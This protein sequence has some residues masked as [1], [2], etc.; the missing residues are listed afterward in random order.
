MPLTRLF[1]PDGQPVGEYEFE[2][3]SDQ[4]DGEQGDVAQPI[5]LRALPLG[6]IS[7]PKVDW[8]YAVRALVALGESDGCEVLV[9]CLTLEPLIHSA[10]DPVKTQTAYSRFDGDV[11]A[12]KDLVDLLSLPSSPDTRWS[13]MRNFLGMAATFQATGSAAIAAMDGAGADLA[14]EVR[15]LLDLHPWLFLYEPFVGHLRSVAPGLDDLDDERAAVAAL[16]WRPSRGRPQT[17]PRVPL[18]EALVGVEPSLQEIWERDDKGYGTLTEFAV[19]LESD[20][21]LPPALQDKA[22]KRAAR[23]L[24]RKA[25]RTAQEM[26]RKRVGYHLLYFPGETVPAMG[27][28]PRSFLLEWLKRRS[29]TIKLLVMAWGEADRFHL[30]Q[31]HLVPPWPPE[32]IEQDT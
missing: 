24:A 8:R 13:P 16:S 18:D 12:I 28:E 23:V 17:L 31:A 3:A 25:R 32:L 30:V 22:D 15:R 14:R 20:Q 6:T 19:H 1:F 10:F 5:R 26:I 9:P 2:A 27:A 11:E 7:P 21:E 29:T 4:D